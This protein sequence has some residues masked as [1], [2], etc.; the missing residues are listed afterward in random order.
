MQTK[1]TLRIEDDLI[2]KA[3]RV[4]YKRGKS[5]SSIVA[6]YF[7]HISSDEKSNDL[8]LPPNV[9]SLFGSLADSKIDEGTYKKHLEKKYL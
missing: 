4:A 7:N 1:L 3:K 6:E 8:N 5:L 2:K 9:R